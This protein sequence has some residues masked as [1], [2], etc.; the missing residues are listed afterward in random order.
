MEE[1]V[2]I[3]VATYKPNIVYLKQQIDSIL[4]QTYKNIQIII[5]DD[6]SED[7]NVIE[8]LKQYQ[9]QEN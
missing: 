4:N 8:V 9:K 3:L 1:T 2:D 5:S 7:K 6:C